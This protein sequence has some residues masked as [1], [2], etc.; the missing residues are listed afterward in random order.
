V[1]PAFDAVDGSRWNSIARANVDAHAACSHQVRWFARDATAEPAH[2]ET[3]VDFDVHGR[4]DRFRCSGDGASHDVCEWLRTAK[5]WMNRV[6]MLCR[7]A[8]LAAIA[9]GF[10]TLLLASTASSQIS[11][12][13]DLTQHGLTG[14]WYDRATSGQGFELEV[15]PNTPAPGYARIFLGWFTYDTVAG[16]AGSQR[17]Y[18]LSGNVPTGSFIAPLTIYQNT[19]GNFN[20]PPITT[21]NAVGTATLS[22]DTCSSG[23]LTYTFTDGSGRRGNIGLTRLT[24]NVTCTLTYLRPTNADFALSGTWYSAATSGQGFAVEVN[25]ISGVLFYAWY[26]YMPNGAGAGE[27]GQR[28]YTG[29]SST[30]APGTRSIP[31]TIYETTGGV[32]DAPT[33]KPHSTPVGTGTVT[34]QGCGSATVDYIFTGGSSSGASGTIVLTRIGPVP[35]GCV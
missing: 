17:W 1:G 25:P 12:Y 15:Y 7:V 35:R 30:F 10:L 4:N 2:W 33:P 34:F 14:S 27:A 6:H 11:D 22:F 9:L 20:G 8:R 21:S 23:E 3:T 19:D 24:Q 5:R 18:S 13:L 31:V 16:G 28:W 32:F 26:T 29:Q